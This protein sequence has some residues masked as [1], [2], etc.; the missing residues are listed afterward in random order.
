MMDALTA[1]KQAL[2]ALGYGYDA[3]RCTADFEFISK[4]EKDLRAGIEQVKQ[5]QAENAT[6]SERLYRVLVGLPQFQA[7]YCSQCGGL[8][9]PGNHGFSSCKDHAKGK[10]GAGDTANSADVSADVPEAEISE[11]E[12]NEMMKAEMRRAEFE[13]DMRLD[14]FGPVHG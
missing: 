5:L 2:E 12:Y 8:F 7:V 13:A 10:V 9:G 6:L 11:A 1:M 4:A 3:A 14:T